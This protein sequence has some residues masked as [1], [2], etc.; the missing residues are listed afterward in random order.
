MRG[1]TATNYRL[2]A[3]PRLASTTDVLARLTTQQVFL[4]S[5][6]P[7]ASDRRV[8]VVFVVYVP[9]ARSLLRSVINLGRKNKLSFS[10]SIPYEVVLVSRSGTDVHEKKK[11]QKKFAPGST[12]RLLRRSCALDGWSVPIIVA[13]FFGF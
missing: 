2:A 12:V 9:G 8:P 6:L 10:S 13:C 3:S 5:F 11:K 7:S 4:P 1:E